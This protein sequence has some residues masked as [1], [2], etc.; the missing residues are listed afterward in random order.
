MRSV[1]LGVLVVVAV[2][3]RA[4]AGPKQKGSKRAGDAPMTTALVSHAESPVAAGETASAV[5]TDEPGALGSAFSRCLDWCTDYQNYYAAEFL[6]WELKDPK[7]RGYLLHTQ[8]LVD[9]T[10]AS[11]G[12]FHT[13]TPDNRDEVGFRLTAGRRINDLVSVE[14][15]GYWVNPT[16]HPVQ[17][18]DNVA[19]LNGGTLVEDNV[20]L[21]PGITPT[22]GAALA[23][24]ALTLAELM[25]ELENH[26]IEANTRVLLYNSPKLVVDGLGGIRWI[27]H[28]ENFD[29]QMAGATVGS[30][31]EAFHA[32]NTLL[33]GQVGS[34]VRYN[35]HEYISLHGLVKFGATANIQDMIVRGPFP[36]GGRF[37]GP[38]NLGGIDQ[39]HFAAVFDLGTKIVFH[40]TPNLRAN[41]GYS[42]LWIS[43]VIRPLDQLDLPNSV[44]GGSPTLTPRSDTLWMTGFHAGLELSF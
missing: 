26:G 28:L 12:G 33:G 18:L 1:F 32:K 29:I 6:Y 30:I 24:E 22:G 9:G 36:G 23:G 34:E 2:A 11:F 27:D 3:L 5:E 21:A 15:G 39:T 31:H 14:V 35:V 38:G 8:R 37:T 10:V 40:L 25:Y 44:A 17:L 7:A 43:D 20:S 16:A 42:A 4:D 19:L 13:A 41:M